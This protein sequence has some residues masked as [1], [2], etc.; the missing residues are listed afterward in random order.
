MHRSLW[1]I[2]GIVLILSGC[3]YRF[4]GG[5]SFPGGIKSVFVEI[6]ENKTSEVGVESTFTNDLIYEITRTGDVRLVSLDRAEGVLSGAITQIGTQTI[7][8]KDQKEAAERRLTVYV[9]LKLTGRNGKI[10][11]LGNGIA[12]NETYPVNDES[13]EMTEKNKRD[14]FDKLSRRLAEVINNRLTSDF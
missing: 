11:W 4:V 10:V 5:G 1:I 7:S 3:G 13:K 2:L 6:L 8:R 14:A 9:D 12:A